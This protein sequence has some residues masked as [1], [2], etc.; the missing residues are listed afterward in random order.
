MTCFL[1][2]FLYID[3]FISFVIRII[4]IK[5]LVYSIQEN[6]VSGFDAMIVKET[7]KLKEKNVLIIEK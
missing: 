6:L 3:E 2:I 7:A 4:K 1:P 5:S